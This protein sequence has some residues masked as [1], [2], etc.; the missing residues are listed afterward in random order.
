MK[1]VMVTLVTSHDNTDFDGLA[2]MVAARKL[3]PGAVLVRPPGLGGNVRRFLS[4]HKDRFPVVRPESVDPASVARL[5]V[6]DTRRATRLR[7]V[8]A[9]LARGSGVA[10]EAWDHHPASPDDVVAAEEHLGSVGSTVTLFVEAL[11]A[12]KARLDPVEATLLALGLHAD[13]GSLAHAGST[14]RDAEALAWIMREGAHLGVLNRFLQPAFAAEQRILLMALLDA[15]RVARFGG[16]PVGL[17]SVSVEEAITRLGDVA[18]E[19]FLL[20]GHAAFVALVAIPSRNKVHVVA[21]SRGAIVD[22]GDLCA[23][24]GGGGHA[25]AG[26]ATVQGSLETVERQVVSLLGEAVPTTLAVGALMSS[27]VETV[28]PECTLR[29]ASARMAASGISGMPV[30]AS[31]RV[32]GMLSVEDVAGAKERGQLDLPVSSCMRS[33]VET[34]DVGLPVEAALER[35]VAADMGR[36]P[37]MREDRLVGIV[38]RSDVRRAIYGEASASAGSHKVA[39]SSTTT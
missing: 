10:V 13:T 14:S 25:E 37:V 6:V 2:S 26:A 33:P 39:P 1:G 28:V 3:H 19:V 36:L 15:V 8:R 7:H 24:F 27:P 16:L 23:R 12:R 32:V 4:L 38:T 34:A 31:R 30:V 17:S 18:E 29:E 9:V 11:R 35:M 21:R 20:S 22:V 5:V